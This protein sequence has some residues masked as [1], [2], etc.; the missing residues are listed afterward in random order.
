MVQRRAAEIMTT[1]YTAI[2]EGKSRKIVGMDAD[3]KY[4]LAGGEELWIKPLKI[5]TRARARR[6]KRISKLT[7]TGGEWL[8]DGENLKC[9]YFDATTKSH[10]SS[11]EARTEAE[12]TFRL[13]EVLNGVSD[14]DRLEI[15]GVAWFDEGFDAI[16]GETAKMCAVINDDLDA[17][18]G[19]GSHVKRRPLPPAKK[20]RPVLL[21]DFQVSP[22]YKGQGQGANSWIQG[23]SA[24]LKPSEQTAPDSL[25]DMLEK[26]INPYLAGVENVP[27]QP[28][29]PKRARPKKARQ[30]KPVARFEND[31]SVALIPQK[32][33][34]EKPITIEPELLALIMKIITAGG[35]MPRTKLR[36]GKS[37]SYQPEKLLMSKAAKS[38]IKAKLLG[39]NKTGRATVFWA[40]QR[41]E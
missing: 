24:V 25:A 21:T 7:F 5:S 27:A 31:F 34:K 15:N 39:T 26:G 3:G 30:P 10:E 32:N 16:K 22:R 8:L 1:S 11:G 14:E 40:K 20:F 19:V 6:L 33:G 18:A 36:K 23:L 2:I 29:I 38:L 17:L 37:D 12:T 9:R 28:T 4:L 13:L 41:A 35:N